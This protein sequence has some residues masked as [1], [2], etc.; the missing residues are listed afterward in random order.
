MG[1]F[2]EQLGQQMAGTAAGGIMGMLL[3]GYN[4]ERQR[5]QQEEL[6]NM[7]IRGNKEMMDYGMAKQLQMWKDTNFSAQLAEMKKAGLSPG[8]IYGK[9]GAGG[10]TVGS[11][12]GG[13]SGATA[14]VGG[15]EVQDMIGMGMQLQLLKAQ[16]ENIEADTANKRADIPIKGAQVP[17][18][19]ASTANI[20]ATTTLTEVKTELAKIEKEIAGRSK[21]DVL[22]TIGHNALKVIDEARSALYKA[23]ADEATWELEIERVKTDLAGLYLKNDQTAMA[24]AKTGAEIKQI[25]EQLVQGWHKLNI[26]FANANTGRKRY[27]LDK[28]VNDISN[29]TKLTVETIKGIIQAI[30]IKGR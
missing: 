24:I 28:W 23:N 8:L 29:S 3:G 7:Q 22:T 12:A 16:K 15:R 21:E 25:A 30:L 10:T 1:Q 19:Q 5:R 9:G 27:E 13:V 2:I 18:I 11:P 14:P 17:N 6:Q 26:D 20:E 4:D